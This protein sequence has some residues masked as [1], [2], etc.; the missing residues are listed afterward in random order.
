MHF[1]NILNNNNNNNNSNTTTTNNKRNNN[2][3]A[4]TK[5]GESIAVKNVGMLS[6]STLNLLCG[7]SRRISVK[8]GAVR[9]GS[10]FISTHFCRDSAF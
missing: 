1:I 10:C 7:L 6:L 2:K 3:T 5:P 4:A 9:Q 8:S